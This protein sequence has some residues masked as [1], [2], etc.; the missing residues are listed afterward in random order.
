MRAVSA[1]SALE[2]EAAMIPMVKSTTTGIPS[3]PVA[4]N[5]GSRSSPEAGKAIPIFE[6]KRTRRTPRQRNRRLAG[7]K[8]TP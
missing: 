7:T 6:V 2:N 5:I 8:A 4:A 1:E 3:T